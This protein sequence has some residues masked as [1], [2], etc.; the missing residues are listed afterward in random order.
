VPGQRRV[1]NLL[2]LAILATLMGRPMH[3]YE[4]AAVMRARGKDRDMQIKW[5]SLYRVVDNLE[6]HGLIQAVQSERRGGRPERT[7]YRITDEGHAE[8]V[9]WARE[10]IRA[11][12]AVADP[13]TAGLSVFGVLGPDEV[14]ALLRERLG[15]LEAQISDDRTALAGFAAEV[16]RIFLV[17]SEYELAMREAELAWVRGLLREIGEGTLPGVDQ[18]RTFHR[19]GE[20][21][22]ELRALAERGT[23]PHR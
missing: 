4:M 2:G 19:T 23:D 5:G 8:L 16:P 13:F 15:R 3:P 7:V 9:D 12:Q 20:M 1:G 17:E 21:P 14:E 11:P 6:R 22:P 18:W 10:L